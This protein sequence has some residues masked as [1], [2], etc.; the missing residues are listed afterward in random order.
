M[1]EKKKYRPA[2][3]CWFSGLLTIIGFC[4][5]FF[6]VSMKVSIYSVGH[7]ITVH[8]V[9]VYEY[10][11]KSSYA[12]F[13]GVFPRFPQLREAS[14]RGTART[15]SADAAHASGELHRGVSVAVLR[16]PAE[17]KRKD[18][19]VL[20]LK[21]AAHATTTCAGSWGLVGEHCIE[22][23]TPLETAK[24][25]LA[26]ELGLVGGDGVEVVD[27]SEG[28][29]ILVQTPYDEKSRDLQATA[30]FAAKL[31]RRRAR[32]ITFDNRVEDQKWI[33]MGDLRDLDACTPELEAFHGIVADRLWAA[34]DTP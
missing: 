9:E 17:R 34:L 25:S 3:P 28:A 13:A 22:G 7:E 20:L 11:G 23:E 4:L 6:I 21:R 19:D 26:E 5:A 10:D 14:L 24:R 2:G 33:P 1:G 8:D 32:S 16:P 18:F 31:G 15:V 29:G 12:D 30:I 27:L